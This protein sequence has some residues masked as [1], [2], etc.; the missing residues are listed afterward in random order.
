MPK[1]TFREGFENSPNNPNV[2]SK[3]LTDLL[4]R[5]PNIKQPD[6][7]KRTQEAIKTIEFER[8]ILRLSENL[9]NVTRDS[10]EY[11]IGLESL[12]RELGLTKTVLEEVIETA[13]RTQ[14]A[15][16]EFNL[17][18]ASIA[19][20]SRAN[21]GQVF[22]SIFRYLGGIPSIIY[23]GAKAF[24]SM[25]LSAN[26]AVATIQ[27]QFRR[28]EY[29]SVT[30]FSRIQRTDEMERAVSDA[31]AR[32]VRIG[33]TREEM[34]GA[35]GVVAR[36]VAGFPD[37]REVNIP[38]IALQA[39]AVS[40]VFGFDL[41]KSVRMTS[42]FIMR[43][44]L[45]GDEVSKKFFELQSYA[46]ISGISLE[47]FTDYFQE[48]NE[49]S[50]LYLK[51]QRD[52]TDIITKFGR[53]LSL[54]IFSVNELTG[55]LGELAKGPPAQTLGRLMLMEQAGVL[56]TSRF[57]EPI[58]IYGSYM[59]E[60]TE[61]QMQVLRAGGPIEDIVRETDVSYMK[62]RVEYVEKL[63]E[64]V[65]VGQGLTR[66][67]GRAGLLPM[68]API[69][70]QGLPP[71][72]A[73]LFFELIKRSDIESA[74]QLTGGIDYN[75][76]LYESSKNYYDNMTPIMKRLV[77]F[78]ESTAETARV[79][80]GLAGES[81]TESTVRTFSAGFTMPGNIVG[82]TV[83]SAIGSSFSQSLIELSK[84]ITDIIEESIDGIKNRIDNQKRNI[85]KDAVMSTL[86]G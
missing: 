29:E 69:M 44:G 55:Y 70:F 78:L 48:L 49:A 71:E 2:L 47:K 38:E 15:N 86:S 51:S 60:L 9:R 18:K 82:E 81:L 7:Y 40:K 10:K 19:D 16:R 85:E 22:Y 23:T 73:N 25:E 43:L 1:T 62:Q 72:K 28:L 54:G 52:A 83:S 8:N 80:L 36:E 27:Q 84:K 46:S 34:R 66:E 5:T 14:V 32:G 20:I 11:E 33:I 59:K 79:N 45:R 58:E 6:T 24:E 53:S 50:F 56:P 13:K 61:R 74:K 35:M 41:T 42:D 17:L 30:P 31:I 77:S 26:K 3:K 75:K 21:L 68:I 65:R 76:L 12:S 4:T 63:V 67:E 64:E 57:G 37:I 39:Q